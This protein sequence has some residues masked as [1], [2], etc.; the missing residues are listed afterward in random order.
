[1]N[2]RQTASFLVISLVLF[3]GCFIDTYADDTS[4]GKAV[5]LNMAV[6]FMDHAAAA[7]IARDQGWFEDAGL[8]VRSY[9][10]YA[11][12]MALASALARGDVQ[13]AYL[14]LAPAINAFVNAG[15]P[16]KI[17]A[18][19]HKYGYGLVVD[20]RRVRQVQDLRAPGIRLGCVREGGAADVLL[21][22]IIDDAGLETDKAL[23]HVRRMSPAQLL[24]AL[25]TGQLDAAALPEQWATMAEASGFKMHLTARD[26]WPDMQ[27]SVLVVR[28]DLIGTRPET[29]KQ[30][31]ALLD[32]G[33]R[34][35]HNDPRAAAE[36][37]SRQMRR[38]GDEN[39]LDSGGTINDL[40]TPEI[41]MRSMGRLA[42]TTAIDPRE[43]QKTIDY[44][45]GLGYIKKKVAA[46][47][48]LDLRFL[49]NAGVQ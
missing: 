4:D 36:I 45:A 47:E 3:L 28:N 27:G 31:V 9:E 12:G 40:L 16:V 43:V 30:L 38:I 41:L 46:A 34:L 6:E 32:R 23:G 13:V 1:M 39:I 24:L 42:F 37:V 14:C 15:V 29:V 21:R 20:G 44:M 22:R 5:A 35:I 2:P 8:R 10:T 17:V 7:F 48:L 33:N 25:K 26:V 18:G 49:D 11:S 19:T